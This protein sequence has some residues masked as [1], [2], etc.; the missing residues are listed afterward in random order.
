[1][2]YFPIFKY[3]TAGYGAWSKAAKYGEDIDDFVH[4]GSKF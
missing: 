3:F 4:H 1:M 2:I